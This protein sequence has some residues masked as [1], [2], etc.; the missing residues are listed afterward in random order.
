M[1][2][3]KKRNLAISPWN[4]GHITSEAREY[5]V[6]TGRWAEDDREPDEMHVYCNHGVIVAKI[7]IFNQ[8]AF[9]S[10]VTFN[11]PPTEYAERV[12]EWNKESLELHIIEEK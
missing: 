9:D 5:R 2:E 1:Q 6:G 3:D 7:K 11:E 12:N 4:C 10:M 8:A